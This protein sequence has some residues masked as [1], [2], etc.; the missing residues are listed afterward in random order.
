MFDKLQTEMKRQGISR[1]KLALKANI[2]VPDLYSAMSGKKPFFPNWRKRV[3]NV[4]CVDEADIF[5]DENERG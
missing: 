4:L 3:A 5:D 2:A 1:Y